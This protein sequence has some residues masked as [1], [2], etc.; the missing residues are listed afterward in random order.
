MNGIGKDQDK[1]ITVTDPDLIEL[2]NLTRQFL[3]KEKN[4]NQPKAIVASKTVCMFNQDY[5]NKF[6]VHQ[7]KV[8]QENEYLFNKEFYQNKDLIFNALD[9]IPARLYM[10]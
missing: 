4:I 8:C 3:F 2:S 7:E 10:D 6:E 1:G 9:N 5:K